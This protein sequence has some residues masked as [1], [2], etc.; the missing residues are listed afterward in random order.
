VGLVVALRVAP[1][2]SPASTVTPP[3][4]VDVSQVTLSPSGVAAR[5]PVSLPRPARDT[6]AL[7]PAELDA[8]IA[9]ALDPGA[10]LRARIEAARSL[11]RSGHDEAIAAL[12]RLLR[13]DSPH[14]LA[15]EAAAALG[16]SPHPE[17]P[18]IVES[19]LRSDDEAVL[20]G[21]VRALARR[22]DPDATERLRA[23]LADARLPGSVRAEAAAALGS[24][25]AP[26]ATP[27]LC[28][29][30]ERAPQGLAAD[31]L[32]ALGSRPFAETEEF[33]RALLTDPTASGEL[34]RTALAVLADSTPE[35]APLLVEYARNAP[36]AEQRAAAAEA[37]ALLADDVG[38]AGALAA[39][40]ESEESDLARAELYNGLAFHARDTYAS[41]NLGALVSGIAA[42]TSP[43]VQL[44]GYRLV[45]AM[46]SAEADPRLAEPFDRVM[47]PWL[48]HEAEAG[49]TRH[50]RRLAVDALKLAG[51]PGS[52]R[53]LS[54]L[55]RSADPEIALAA[56]QA[57]ETR[58]RI[59]RSGA[60]R[61]ATETENKS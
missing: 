13:G 44:Q 21:A 52:A 19:L 50:A 4:A 43:P 22:A 45:A 54:A 35:A 51:T 40:L 7:D 31:I 11:A 17:A 57:L 3:D 58:A 42:E 2:E 55:T 36:D 33:F 27:L 10:P 47:A 60:I 20:R 28:E 8:Q 48:A 6:R 29:A 24:L 15:L 38:A 14:L 53:A 1:P 9:R 49:E 56:E 16:D 18:R 61:R 41:A 59:E 12:E 37:L 30:F 25:A 23:L 39:L 5:A 32:A 46:L 26:E 34:R